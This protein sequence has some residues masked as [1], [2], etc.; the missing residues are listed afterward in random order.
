VTELDRI[1]ALSEPQRRWLAARL[2]AAGAAGPRPV[3]RRLIAFV[4]R[5]LGQA[6]DEP[7]LRRHLA[8]AL[9]DYMV[10][11]TIVLLDE[12]PHTASGKV[13]LAALQRLAATARREV[14]GAPGPP[15]DETERAVAAIWRD[16]LGVE[17][18]GRDES[19]FDLG[20]HSLLLIRLQSRLRD[21]LGVEL[22][23]ADLFRFPTVAT[24]AAAVRARH[25]HET[26]AGPDVSELAARAASQRAAMTRRAPAVRAK[27]EPA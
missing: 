20:G 11:A 27:E 2:D 23:V 26:A 17:R 18:V 16:L 15:R 8:A 9:P 13:D 14:S 3:D 22:A 6:V 5:R 24:L 1:A 25:N 10:P 12:L 19:F 4:S 21:L 7:V